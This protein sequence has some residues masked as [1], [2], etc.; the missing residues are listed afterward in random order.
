M[1]ANFIPEYL[2]IDDGIILDL[3][4]MA[5]SHKATTALD[6]LNESIEKSYADS[7]LL[8]L[9]LLKQE[10]VS[11]TRIEG[12]QIDTREFY[13]FEAIPSKQNKDSQEVFNYIRA[14]NLGEKHIS[15]YNKITKVLIREMHKEL[16]SNDVR[17]SRKHP[18][19]F[20]KMENYIGKPNSKKEQADFIPPRP[21]LTQD[22]IDNLLGYMNSEKHD[23][24]ILIKLAII[25]SQFETIHPFEG[26]NGRIGRV[27]IPLFLYYKKKTSQPYFFLSKNLEKNKFQYYHNLNQTRWPNNWKDW[28]MFFFNK[29]T[30]QV[31][32]S[33]ETVEK[34]TD[35]YDKDLKL[36]QCKHKSYSIS[37][38]LKS[39][40]KNP[41]FSIKN[42][43]TETG[44][45][46]STCRDYTYTLLEEKRVFPNENK[47]NTR[48]YHYDLLDIIAK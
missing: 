48:F 45:S 18:G 40:Y 47:R 10:A 17:G 21:E 36:L 23:E 29:I 25:H 1:K 11:S 8:I 24:F 16:L 22:Y 31:E 37:E 14:I 12:T 9:P 4:I 32:E 19:E 27:L 30:E 42:I 44:I 6:S 20:K 46:Y 7:K 41:I 33:K 28:L 26:G 15:D 38:F 39:V 5:L 43:S 34:I 3:D 2:P 13:E 35:L